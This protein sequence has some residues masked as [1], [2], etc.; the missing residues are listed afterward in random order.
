MTLK[1]SSELNIDIDNSQ[2]KIN[3]EKLNEFYTTIILKINYKKV[4][5]IFL[6]YNF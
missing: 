1:S 2:F 6:K 3:H 4:K 5:E